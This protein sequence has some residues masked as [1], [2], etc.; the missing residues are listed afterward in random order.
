MKNEFT[1]IKVAFKD[2]NMKL[3]T[4]EPNRVGTKE[5][6]HVKIDKGEEVELRKAYEE[7]KKDVRIM[8]QSL[9]ELKKDKLDTK[10]QIKNLRNEIKSQKEDY[11]QC[12]EALLKETYDK[13]KAETCKIMKDIIEAEKKL[14]E[15]I[16]S[17]RKNMML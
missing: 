11:K 8:E 6:E 17:E 1:D 15:S 3:K 12:M 9:Q 16:A 13:N 10:K 2:D 4:L 5:S 7:I 14:K